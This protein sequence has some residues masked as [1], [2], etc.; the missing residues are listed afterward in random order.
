MNAN[1][2]FII[3]FC[4]RLRKLRKRLNMNIEDVAERCD[5]TFNQIQRLECQII[6]KDDEIIIKKSGANG[7]A[8]TV[9]TLINFYGQKVSLDLLFDM[10]YPVADIPISTNT[11]VK[12]ISRTKILA[13]VNELTEIANNI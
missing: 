10:N 9:L 8:A 4:D 5:L 11:V 13:L 1:D 2:E 12:E 6:N 3:R 7:T